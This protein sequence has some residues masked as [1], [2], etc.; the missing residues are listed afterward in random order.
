MP[1]LSHEQ[2]IELIRDAQNGSTSALD[3]LTQSNVALVRCVAKKYVQRSQTDFDDLYQIGCIG[4]IKAI[5]K[6]DFSYNVRFSTYAVPMIAGEIKRFLRDDGSIKISRSIKEN[7][8]HIASVTDELRLK[9]G[10]EPRVEDIA[11]HLGI[12]VE[13]AVLAM[14]C[15]LPAVSLQKPQFDSEN[16][17]LADTL[18]DPRSD[19]LHLHERIWLKEILS[20]LEPRARTVI[21]LHYFMDQT[22]NQIA[23]RLGIS[24]VQVSRIESKVFEQIRKSV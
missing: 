10:R 14:E 5:N 4:L 13:E 12:S 17:T 9:L 2:T 15:N 23:A 1:L 22:Q 21:V 24:Q 3:T 19:E 20:Q 11:R 7:A 16:N 8:A 18:P 6:Y